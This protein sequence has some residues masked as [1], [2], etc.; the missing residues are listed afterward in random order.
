MAETRNRDDSSRSAADIEREIDRT[1]A[2]IDET[3]DRIFDRLTPGQAFE[4]AID[5]VRRSNGASTFGRALKNNPI[6]AVLTVVG[7][8]WLIAATM[9]EREREAELT[10][11]RWPTREADRAIADRAAEANTEMGAQSTHGSD[12]EAQKTRVFTT[13][14]AGS[15]ETSSL[16][17]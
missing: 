2:E 11:T 10:G 13:S 6:P 3:L 8:G 14:P 15:A 7:I 17:T 4:Q 9:R 1:R 12:F 5:Y 16:K